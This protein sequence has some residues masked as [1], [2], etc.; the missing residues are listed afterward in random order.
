MNLDAG[1]VNA[2]RLDADAHHLRALQLLEHA[3][4]DASFGPAV[5]ARVDRVPV[6]ESL[7]QA[8]PLAAV[9][10]DV[11]DR[12]DHLQVGHAHVAALRGQAM[13]DLGK[14]LERDFHAQ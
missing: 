4:Q 2:H 7:G 12:I 10:G 5:H 8:S 14:L 3:I 11:K 13:F 9:L 1:A 6:A